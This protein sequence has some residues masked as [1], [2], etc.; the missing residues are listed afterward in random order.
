MNFNQPTLLECLYGKKAIDVSCGDNFTV[1]IIHSEGSA[2][3]FSKILQS[4]KSTQFNNIKEKIKNCRSYSQSLQNIYPPKNNLQPSTSH[5]K[6]R[7][8][9]KVEMPSERQKA[10]SVSISM[11]REKN[12]KEYLNEQV[13]LNEEAKKYSIVLQSNTKIEL[14]STEKSNRAKSAHVSRKPLIPIIIYDKVAQYANKKDI[15]NKAITKIPFIYNPEIGMYKSE[16][17]KI[18]EKFSENIKN[19]KNNVIMKIYNNE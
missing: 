10:L 3:I 15:D 17:D 6:P 14:L 8:I 18:M 11:K 12:K 4:F 2:R 19:P 5:K 1:A 13:L 7:S 9:T 16:E